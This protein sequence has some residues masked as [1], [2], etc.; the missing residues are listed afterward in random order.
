MSVHTVH[1]QRTDA[2][3]AVHGDPAFGEGRMYRDRRKRPTETKN[4]RYGNGDFDARRIFAKGERLLTRLLVFFENHDAHGEFN[5][6][7]V[8]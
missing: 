8:F 4:E 2:G 3:S 5:G 1:T 7:G 6:H